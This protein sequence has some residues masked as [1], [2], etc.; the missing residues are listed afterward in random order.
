MQPGDDKDAGPLVDGIGDDLAV[1]ELQIERALDDC[2]WHLEQH[3]G[4]RQELPLMST[5]I[6]VGTLRDDL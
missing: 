1:I 2:G 6:A 3:G 5:Q 4:Y